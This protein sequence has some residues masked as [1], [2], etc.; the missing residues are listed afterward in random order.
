[1]A[2]V[3][4]H[5]EDEVI[6]L[7]Q[8][9]FETHDIGCTQTE[10]TRTLQDMQTT[11]KLISHQALNNGSSTI[12]TSVIDNE[13]IKLLFETEDS[14]DDFL[15]VFLLIICRNDYYAITHNFF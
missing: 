14:T 2:E 1:M 10:F 11:G 8:R 3:G 9:P 5:L 15:D 12:R 4:I 6:A 7:L 13:D